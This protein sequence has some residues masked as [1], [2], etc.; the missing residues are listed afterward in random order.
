MRTEP[1]FFRKNWLAIVSIGIAFVMMMVFFFTTD[2]L[3]TLGEL[4]GNMRLGW[5]GVGVGCMLVFW[6]LEGVVIHLLVRRVDRHYSLA[7]SVQT[8]MVGQF[9]SAVTPFSTGGQP[10]QVLQMHQSGLAVGD[11]TSIITLKS[12]IFQVVLVVYA[13]VCVIAKMDYFQNSVSNFSFVAAVG[14]AVQVLVIAVI[15]VLASSRVNTDRAVRG[16]LRF[17]TRIHLVKNPEG[18]AEKVQEQLDVFHRSL[19]VAPRDTLPLALALLLTAVQLTAFF[20]VPYC[21]YRAFGFSEASFFTMTAAMAFV[22]VVSMF[23]PLPGASG[24]AE[25]SFLL[26]FGLFFQA[27][28]I[29]SAILLWRILTYYLNI[30][31]GCLFT[32]RAKRREKLGAGPDVPQA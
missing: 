11:A 4:S 1:G 20:A 32:F 19:R 21:I 31:V 2:S 17:L 10:M 18:A 25:G 14:L 29:T 13:M 3:T 23:V 8:G 24:G 22:Y 9:Y 6:L 28:T 26:F 5:L 7:T 15:V 12:L 27:G 30:G 16:M